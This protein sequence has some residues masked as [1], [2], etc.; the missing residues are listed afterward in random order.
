MTGATLTGGTITS[1]DPWFCTPNGCTLDA[2]DGP[3]GQTSPLT[4]TLTVADRSDDAENCARGASAV[5]F[6]PPGS[7]QPTDPV[8]IC[9]G[10]A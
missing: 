4:A 7:Q 2:A 3:F 1:A 6:A 10:D 8:V 9:E 5:G